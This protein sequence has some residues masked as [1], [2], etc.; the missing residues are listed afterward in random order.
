MSMLKLCVIIPVKINSCLPTLG[1][2]QSN[3][4]SEIS[5]I[6]HE[7]FYGCYSG[8][9][10]PITSVTVQ[11]YPSTGKQDSWPALKSCGHCNISAVD[12]III[13]GL[14]SKGSQSCSCVAFHLTIHSNSL[15]DHSRNGCPKSVR[16]DDITLMIVLFSDVCQSQL[17]LVRT[18]CIQKYKMNLQNWNI[19]KFWI[20]ST[21]K[22][23]L[24]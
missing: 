23:W 24:I 5:S 19:E 10:L 4:N 3:Q 20:N 15:S 16:L 6:C 8:P 18:T 22:I 7:K 9:C 21:W 1:V 12:N 2:E 14:I 17:W 13:C 11:S